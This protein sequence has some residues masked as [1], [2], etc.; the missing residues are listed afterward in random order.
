[1]KEAES[2]VSSQLQPVKRRRKPFRD[3]TGERIGRLT[4]IGEGPLDKWKNKQWACLCDCGKE[5]IIAS[6]SIR[7]GATKSCG[8]L[9]SDSARERATKHGLRLHPLYT[10]WKGMRQRCNDSRSS[11]YALYGGRGIT[12]CERWKSF[13]SFLEDM[14]EKPSPD[15][16]IERKN[17]NLGYSKDNCMWAA[18]EIQ[19]NNKRN[20]RIF[21]LGD[22]AMTLAQWAREIGV[23]RRTLALRMDK[24]GWTPERALTTKSGG[25]F[26]LRRQ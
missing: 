18:S 20:N 6:S 9:N 24:L 11:S 1:M 12:V 19:A 14:G 15:H 8:C 7:S 16:T 2:E 22:K 25:A 3:F 5:K 23:P 13:A 17:N 10:T 4:V 26:R 21:T